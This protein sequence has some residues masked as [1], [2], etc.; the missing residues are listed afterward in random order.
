MGAADTAAIAR[1]DKLL[2]AIEP[3]I[4]SGGSGGA[5]YR[6]SDV[7]TREMRV[8]ASSAIER[9][10]P[11]QSTYRKQTDEL[12]K[13]AD[14][15]IV[16]RQAAILRALRADI[17]DGYLVGV[18]E[19]LN[20]ALFDDLL[21]M[22]SELADKRYHPAAAVLAGSVLE[23]HLRKLAAKNGIAVQKGGRPLGVEALAVALVK[24]A[25]LSQPEKKMIDSWYAQRTAGAHGRIKDVVPGEVE[26]L[27]PAIRE[28]IVAHPA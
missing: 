23:E 26:R 6:S 25:V 8:R 1:I 16:A 17:Q 10:A 11:P 22:A 12:E 18:E 14:G 19:L 28:F 20:A 3:K 2:E 27:I 21:G 13:Y 5:W 9:I 24:H 4:E 7:E 15:F